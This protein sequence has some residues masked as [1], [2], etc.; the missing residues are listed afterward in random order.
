MGGRPRG[1]D[2]G[3]ACGL[4]RL[5]PVMSFSHRDQS[6]RHLQSVHPSAVGTIVGRRDGRPAAPVA[7]KNRHGSSAGIAADGH[8]DGLRQ[9]GHSLLDVGAGDRG[10]I[11]RPH[12]RT[13]ARIPHPH[14]GG[15]TI[16]RPGHASTVIGRFG[17]VATPSTESGRTLLLVIWSVIAIGTTVATEMLVGAL[18]VMAALIATS[19]VVIRVA[20]D[21]RTSSCPAL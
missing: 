2:R 1:Q 21:C 16:P 12:H 9:V 11:G 8:R 18:V 3:A 4:R 5:R 20:R 15:E 17:R 7:D 14:F 19:V 13:W 6:P 10:D